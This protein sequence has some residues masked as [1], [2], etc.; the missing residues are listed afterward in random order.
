MMPKTYC[1]KLDKI[2]GPA[3]IFSGYLLMLVG[4]TTVYFSLSVIALILLGAALT[5]SYNSMWID[6]QNG[7]FRPHVRLFGFLKIGERLT[8]PETSELRLQKFTGSYSASSLSNRITTSG[9]TDYRIVLHYG[10]RKITLA[11]FPSEEEAARE[12][13]NLKEVFQK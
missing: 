10:K 7:Y 2:A 12:I 8:I 4:L 3:A 1:Y 5:F 13:N 6:P 9:V 11:K